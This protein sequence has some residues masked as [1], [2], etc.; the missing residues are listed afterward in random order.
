M[1]AI[2]S[3]SG[4]SSAS[5]NSWPWTR[6]ASSQRR[7]CARAAGSPPGRGVLG[8]E[9]EATQHLVER[10]RSIVHAPLA[11]LGAQLQQLDPLGH[12][13][14]GPAIRAYTSSSP[15]QSLARPGQPLDVGEQLA[16]GRIGGEG[17]AQRAEGA[18]L[19]VQLVLADERHLQRRRQLLDRLG[20]PGA[21]ALVRSGSALRRARALGRLVEHLQPLGVRGS[22]GRRARYHSNARSGSSR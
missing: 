9:G 5:A 14:A 17:V 21:G 1:R 12:L 13:G 18:L 16:P 15:R 2:P 11:H 20:G 7:S 22:P 19:V 3:F 6:I 10:A 4:R 8:L